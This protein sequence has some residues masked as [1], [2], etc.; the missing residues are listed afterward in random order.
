M[1]DVLRDTPVQPTRFQPTQAPEEQK[2]VRF[3]RAQIVGTV[4]VVIV[5]WFLWF[6]FTAKSVRF[7]MTPAQAQVEVSGGFQFQLSQIHL[8]RRGAYRLE[9][10]A[11]GYYPFAVDVAVGEPRNQIFSYAMTRLPGR[12]TFASEPDGVEVFVDGQS[13]GVTPLIADVAAGERAIVMT[14]DRYQAAELE[15]DVE[16]R[17]VA[18]SI[19]GTLRPDWADVTIPTDP[20]DAS[21]RIADVE[22]GTTPGPVQILSGEHRI[23]VKL[24]GYK[25]WNDIIRVRAAEP[26]TL[27]AIKLV[28]ADGLVSVRTAPR[29]ASV[30]VNGQYQGVTPTEIGIAPGRSHQIR[31]FKIG[32]AP[33]TRSIRI[34]S[35]KEASLVLELQSLTGALAI[36][37]EPDGVELWIDGQRSAGANRT[38]VLSAVPHEIELRKAGYAGYR[39]TVTPQPGFTQEIKVRLL[40]LEEQRFA[41]LKPVIKTSLGQELVLLQPS[42]IRLGASRREPGRRANEVLREVNLS[43]F[44]YFARKEVTNAEFHKFASGHSSG[45][46]EDTKLDKD[47]QPVSGISWEEAVLYCNWLSEQEGMSTFYDVEFGKVIGSNPDSLGYRLPTESEWAWAARHLDDASALLRFPWGERLPPPDRHG[48]YADRSAAHVVGRIIFGYNDNHIGA[49]P[50]GTFKPNAKGLYDL[51][52]NVAEWTHDFYEIPEPNETLN[53]LGPKDGDYHVIKGS[54]WM[55]GTISELRLAFRDYGAEGRQDVGL[56]IARFAE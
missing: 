52:G 17:E 44:F 41:L 15:L 5:A 6:I 40:T 16:G 56:R 9:A 2:G 25:A 23:Q 27:P 32:Y 3:T 20:P 22:I 24:A 28:Q 30:T 19:S 34:D 13:V 37:S 11:P 46:F 18:Q 55:H 26:V 38:V 8:L 7:D 53:P 29:G 4:A 10:T 33:V 14:K 49:A 54:S 39:K 21:V 48:N 1:N 50:V 12:I 45:S 31:V 43:R 47:D 35:G 42:P 51:G 36:T